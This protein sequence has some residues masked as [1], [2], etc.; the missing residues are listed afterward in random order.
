[1]LIKNLELTGFKSFVDRVNLNFKPG[2]TALV[3]PNGCGKSNIIDAMRWIMGEHNARHLR[4]T[5][6][7]DLIFNGSE[8]RKPTGMAEV[9][10]VLFNA[11]NGNGGNGG[12]GGDTAVTL[13]EATELMITRRLFRSGESEYF[14]NKVPCRQKDIVELFLDSGV[15]T[16]SYSIMEQGK[17]DYIL[18]LKPEERRIL[19]EEAAGI[20]KYRFRKKE[21][22][23]KME[24]TKNNLS[25]LKDVLYEIQVQMRTLELQVKRLKRYRKI[26]DEMRHI[27]LLLSSSRLNALTASRTEYQQLLNRYK[28]DEMHIST[29]RNSFEADLERNRL[30]L[31]E[32]QKKVTDL[33]QNSYTIKNNI[34]NAENHCQYNERELNNTFELI[35]KNKLDGAD[36]ENELHRIDDDIILREKDLQATGTEY[37]NLQNSFNDFS[38]ALSGIKA[39]L[40]EVHNNIEQEKSVLL[41]TAYDKTENK[42]ALMLNRRLQDEITI[43]LNKLS[44]EKQNCHAS[45]SELEHKSLL[46]EKQ[47]NEIIL[48]RE[49]KEKHL[50]EIREKSDHVSKNLLEETARFDDT[51]EHIGTL[52][53]RLQSLEDLQKNLEGFDEGVQTIMNTTKEHCDDIN[54]IVTLF[55]DVIETTPRYERA[56]EAAL[57]RKLQSVVIENI[58][59]GIQAIEYLKTHNAG[60][61]SFIPLSPEN[62]SNLQTDDQP[63]IPLL[64]VVQTQQQFLSVMEALLG[65]VH[66]VKDISSGLDSWKRQSSHGTLVTE[67][68]EVLEPNGLITGG[69]TNGSGSGIL[70]RNREIRESSAELQKLETDLAAIKNEKETLEIEL[71]HTRQ[72]FDTLSTEKQELDILLVQEKTKEEQAAKELYREKEKSRVLSFEESE[73]TATLNNLKSELDQLLVQESKLQQSETT[74]EQ[75]L[76]ELHLQ[77]KSLK[78]RLEQAESQHTDLRVNLAATQ[79]KLENIQSNVQHL[80][81]R[82]ESAQSKIDALQKEKSNLEGKT[83]NLSQEITDTKERLSTLIEQGQQIDEHIDAEK[84]RVQ[85][86]ERSVLATEESLKD[87]RTRWDA[88]EPKIH[89]TELNLSNLSIHL[90]HLNKDLQEKY[91]LSCDQLPAPPEPETFNEEESRER[92]EKLKKRL[93]NIGEVNLGAANEFEELEK[94]YNYLCSQEEDLLQSLESLNKVIIRI[95]RITKQKFLETFTTIDTHFKEIFPMLFNGGRAYMQLT[96]ESNLLETGIEIFAQPPGKKLQNLDLLS[97]GERA[98]TVISLMFAIFLTKPSPFCLMDEIDAPLDD[99]NIGKF[100]IHLRKMAEHSQFIIVTHNKLSMQAADSLYGI[101]MEEQGISK[102]VSVE[103]N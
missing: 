53:A 40:H 34:Q 48:K 21:A 6:M 87:L 16:K 26:K 61:V 15:G 74:K 41:Q 17:V 89:E 76:S 38:E 4:G 90:E 47:L 97:G 32:L 18:S 2:I 96:D 9:S 72:S 19:I 50:E 14:I 78:D 71:Q 81:D 103:L 95:N 45:L 65:D 69:S 73:S 36:L 27:D 56:V 7:E 86:L 31:T 79:Q 20:S 83:A 88:L 29:Q 51:R 58:Q 3:G 60:R 42:N 1:M 62:I 59:D 12:N 13:G 25:R 55:A 5:K 24:S 33:Q 68:G 49:Q 101:T 39:D 44:E 94:R 10:L 8:S 28:D 11:T 93:E 35:E 52:R 98:L 70:K 23:S 46:L 85:E 92:L 63:G 82:Q 54:G 84:T 64:S 75:A 77:E 37:Q 91:A 57:D 99:N 66:V 43:K 30:S 67:D 100:V 22:L 102:V 80:K